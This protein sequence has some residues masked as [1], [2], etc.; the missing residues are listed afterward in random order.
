[1]QWAQASRTQPSPHIL[2]LKFDRSTSESLPAHPRPNWS[3][4]SGRSEFDIKLKPSAASGT[5]WTRTHGL[6]AVA[7]YAVLDEIYCGGSL[8]S[9]SSESLFLSFFFEL[10]FRDDWLESSSSDLRLRE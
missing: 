3:T 9:E 8:S 4:E 7:R 10:L 6:R 1:M 5:E 2:R